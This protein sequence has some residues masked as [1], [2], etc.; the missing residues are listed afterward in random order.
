MPT[1]EEQ[2]VHDGPFSKIFGMSGGARA[3]EGSE[4]RDSMFRQKRLLLSSLRE[5]NFGVHAVRCFATSP[6]TRIA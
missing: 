3:K 5:G 2:N 4:S 6:K 1:K